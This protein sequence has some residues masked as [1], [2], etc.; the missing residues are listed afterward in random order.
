MKNLLKNRWFES[1]DGD[2]TWLYGS[3]FFQAFAGGIWLVVLP[4][5]VKRLGGTDTQVGLCTGLCFG[6]YA[7]GLLIS[8]PILDAFNLKRVVQ[9]GTGSVAICMLVFILVVIGLERAGGGDGIMSVILP[10]AAIQGFLNAMFWPRIGGW[11]S[12]DYEGAALNRRMGVYNATWSF[13]HL[14]GPLA[15]GYM[16]EFSSVLPLLVC[17]TLMTTSFLVVSLAK[18]PAASVGKAK[19]QETQSRIDSSELLRRKYTW[20]GRVAMITSFACVGLMRTQL[21]LL[22]KFDLGFSESDYGAAIMIMCIAVFV[23][24]SLAGKTHAWHYILPLFVAA[25]LMVILS[26]LLIVKFSNLTMFFLAAT[27]VG[28]GQAFVYSSHMYYSLSN[29]VNKARRLTIHEITL[30]LGVIAGSAAGGYLG[31]SLSRDWAFS[32]GL[33]IVAV[34]LVVQAGIWFFHRP[35]RKCNPSGNKGYGWDQRFGS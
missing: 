31:D 28:I 17:L 5:I 6:G 25:Q 15:G 14:A 21:A 4:F 12:I 7:F 18:R 33:V 27:L 22:F 35:H 1:I 11:I 10:L 20:M 32:F 2:A 9:F 29:S 8:G 23:V 19:R 3:V 26:M 13:G 24:F 30:S 16:V 34:G